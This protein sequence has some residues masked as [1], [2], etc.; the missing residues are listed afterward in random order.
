MVHA[1]PLTLV[2]F[3]LRTTLRWPRD[4]DEGDLIVSEMD[5]V[6]PALV[7]AVQKQHAVGDH[8]REEVIRQA[9]EHQ[10]QLALQPGPV[11]VDVVVDPH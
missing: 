10:V 4:H 2:E 1:K 7:A 9:M 5:N 8:Y 11:R 6:I 3:S